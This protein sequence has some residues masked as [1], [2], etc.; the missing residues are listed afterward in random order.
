MPATAT[1]NAVI[2]S[3]AAQSGQVGDDA[4][5]ISLWS[6][7]TG[8]DFLRREGIDNNPAALALGQSF[9][10]AI[11]ELVFTDTEDSANGETNDMA[12]RGIRGKFDGTVYIQ[13]HSGDPGANGTANVI[14]LARTALADSALDFATT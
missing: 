11:G 13:W 4:T 14:G 10:F 9:Q 8:G 3:A 2:T 12:V 5:F 1:N 6:A 7:V